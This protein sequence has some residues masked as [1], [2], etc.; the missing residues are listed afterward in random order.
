MT[1]HTLQ[2]FYLSLHFDPDLSIAFCQPT[3][4]YLVC[5]YPF[6]HIFSF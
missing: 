2:L 6:Y 5:L 1:C 4:L 3:T